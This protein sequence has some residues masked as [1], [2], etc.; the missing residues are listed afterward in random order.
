M[1]VRSILK[2]HIQSHGYSSYGPPRVALT[3]LKNLL[4]TRKKELWAGDDCSPKY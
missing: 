4:V 3:A 2:R 1:C